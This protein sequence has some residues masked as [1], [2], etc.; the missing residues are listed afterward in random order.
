MMGIIA[1]YT[2]GAQHGGSPTSPQEYHIMF[3]VVHLEAILLCFVIFLDFV[4]YIFI[5]IMILVL[6]MMG[7]HYVKVLC[8]K[9]FSL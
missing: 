7:R 2:Q 5:Y 4:I 6:A 8:L 1:R 3:G 9:V